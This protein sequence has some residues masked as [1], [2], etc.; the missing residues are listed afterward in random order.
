MPSQEELSAYYAQMMREGNYKIGCISKR[1]NR[2]KFSY[3]MERIMESCRRLQLTP[4][5]TLLDIGCFTGD[6]LDIA[7]EHGFETYGFDT[8]SEALSSISDRHHVWSGSL[9]AAPR[10]L[11]RFD[12]V[13]LNDTIEHIA[14]YKHELLFIRKRLLRKKGVL[15]I[16]TP[17]ATSSVARLMGYRWGA[18]D[19][20]E[21][22]LVYSKYG[23]SVLLRSSGFHIRRIKRY[24][25]RM[26][27]GYL[28]AMISKWEFGGRIK[29]F[30]L[31]RFAS[32]LKV[33]VYAGDIFVVAQAAG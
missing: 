30:P 27:L 14:D 20:H 7:K 21:H 29:P 10:N 6:F 19:G 16:T 2:I 22:L 18:L 25:K 15:F 9:F 1:S 5:K 4:C 32:R 33:P 28:N 12:L 13:T 31:P 3:L 8:L 26:E 24:S 23:L 11:P 17:D